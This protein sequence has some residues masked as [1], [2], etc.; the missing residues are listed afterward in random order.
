LVCPPQNRPAS[1][2]PARLSRLAAGLISISLFAIGLS[3]CAPAGA[4]TPT[5]ERV[6]NVYSSRHYDADER[7]FKAFQDATGIRPRVITAEGPALL[8]RLKEEGDQTSADVILMVDVGNLSALAKEGLVQPANAPELDALVPERLR[9]PQGQWY[10]LSRRLRVIAYAKDR[11]RP[12]EVASLDALTGP[13]F[14]GKLCARSSTNVYNLSMLAARIERE[15]AEKALAWARG[16][17]ANFARQPQGGDTDQLRAVA[18]GQCDAAIVNH[19]YVVRMQA[20]ADPTDKAA[21]QTLAISLPDQAGAGVHVNV[22]GAALSRY[23]KNRAEALALI[24][25]LA[26]PQAQAQVAALNDE[27]PIGPD[28]ALPPALAALGPFKEDQ[29][30]LTALGARQSQAQQLYEQAGWR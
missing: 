17:A 12:E 20:S 10:G 13:R 8:Q 7:L 6:V 30:P 29:T 22:S 24:A 3:A 15:G 14:K 19:Y 1:A 27:F 9:D 5:A 21:G 18:G 2:A 25:Y 4:P 26:G 28:I 16:V 11:V 23:S